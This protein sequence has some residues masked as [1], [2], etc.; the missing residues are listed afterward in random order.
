MKATTETEPSVIGGNLVL[1]LALAFFRAGL[2]ARVGAGVGAA[3]CRVFL[4][5]LVSVEATVFVFPVVAFFLATSFF[6][7]GLAPD[8]IVGVFF[9]TGV[10]LEVLCLADTAFFF[11]LGAV[12]AGVAFFLAVDD[13]AGAAFFLADGDFT[14]VA[15]FLAGDDLAGAAFS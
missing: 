5:A 7:E 10:F 9:V 3:G 6:F 15:F 4:A 1:A 8:L 2:R 12:L 13:L 11:A 14:G